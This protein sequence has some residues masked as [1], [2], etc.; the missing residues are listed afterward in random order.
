MGFHITLILHGPGGTGKTMLATS[1]FNKMGINYLEIGEINDFKKYD[2]SFH[3]GILIDDIDAEAL[4]RLETLNIIDSHGGKSVRVLYGIIT[5]TALIPRII[6]T[7]KLKDFTKNGANELIR[8]IKD[9]YIP[10][11]IS[12]KFNF[13]INIQNTNNSYYFW[14]SIGISKEKFNNLVQEFAEFRK[15]LPN[16]GELEIN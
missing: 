11:E 5:P 10:K 12:S 3:T 1:I 7:N 13:Q 6:T 15:R 16:D 9:I 2:S 8:R 14:D 4:S